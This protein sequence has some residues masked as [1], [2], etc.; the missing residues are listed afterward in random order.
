ML[1]VARA[2]YSTGLDKDHINPQTIPSSTGATIH[3][4]RSHN[5]RT[6]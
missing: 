3:Q 4:R 1:I 2:V 5:T 6:Q